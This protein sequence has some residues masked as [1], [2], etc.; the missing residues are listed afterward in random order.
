MKGFSIAAAVLG[1]AAIGAVLGIMLAPDKGSNTRAKIKDYL[2]QK[3]VRLP[4]CKMDKLV[5]EI[6]A[7]I[8]MDKA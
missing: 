4:K 8:A 7:E 3:G 1:A 5:D 6:E 2:Y